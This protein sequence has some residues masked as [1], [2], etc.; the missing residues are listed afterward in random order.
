MPWKLVLG[1]A[2]ALLAGWVAFLRHGRRVVRAREEGRTQAPVPQFDVA[3]S[4]GRDCQIP[5]QLQEHGY[6]A[7]SFP[8]DWVATPIDAVCSL[9]ENE[10]DGFLDRDAL[11]LETVPD[12]RGTESRC[13]V[14]GLGVQFFHDFPTDDGFLFTYA[15]VKRKY[16]RRIARFYEV[17]RSGSRIVFLRYPLTREEAV[18]LRDLIRRKFPELVFEIVAV[19]PR[20]DGD[21]DWQIEGVRQVYVAPTKSWDGDSESYGAV[22]E[23]LNLLKATPMEEAVAAT[24]DWAS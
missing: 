16:D 9:L 15:S 8:L 22:F 2:I 5:Y 21:A 7:A 19:N 13:I 12:P 11:H 18:T 1:C 20:E 24:P 10:F 14:N 4:L 17:M 3:I 23:S 6:R